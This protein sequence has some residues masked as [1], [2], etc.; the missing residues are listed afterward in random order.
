MRNLM[1]AVVGLF[2]CGPAIAEGGEGV[3]LHCSGWIENIHGKR[4]GSSKNILIA[5]DLKWI[6]VVD[7]R[8]IKHTYIELS[9]RAGDT[10]QFKY[11]ARFTKDIVTVNFHPRSMTYLVTTKSEDNDVTVE[12]YSCFPIS[13]PFMHKGI[14]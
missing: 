12:S 11:Q 10:F 9:N 2:F 7:G 8:K 5:K 14:R 4:H 1:I 13:N 6:G 3:M